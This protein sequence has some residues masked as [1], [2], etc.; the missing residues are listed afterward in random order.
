MSSDFP[1]RQPFGLQ[2][3]K[4]KAFE[5]EREVRA[6][7]IVPI[8]W[9]PPPST[10]SPRPA[11]WWLDGQPGHL[12][13]VDLHQLIHNVVNAPTADSWFFDVVQRL[14]YDIG[15]DTKVTKSALQ[16]P[17]SGDPS[18]M[19]VELA[20][21]DYLEEIVSLPIPKFVRAGSIQ[22]DETTR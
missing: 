16:E 15:L 14:C 22:T 3:A 7:S 20:A 17:P 4:R 18:D 12:L 9:N 2:L 11:N 10:E 5:H 6:L 19:E 21:A 13:K 1:I 8:D